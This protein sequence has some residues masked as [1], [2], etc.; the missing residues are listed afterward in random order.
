VD[1]NLIL[2]CVVIVVALFFSY[3]N[4]FHDAANAIATS[5]STRAWTPRAALLMAATMNVIGAMMGTAVAKT[6]GKGIISISDYAESPLPEMQQKGLV[7]ILAALLGACIWNLITWWFGLPSSSSHALIGGMVGAGLL[8]GTMVHWW[9]IMSHVVIPMFASPIIGFVIGYFVMKLVLWLLRNAQY[10]RTMRRFR[11]AQRFS[12]AAMALGHGI[13]DAQKT[14]GIIV[15]ALL[16]GGYGETH[17]ILDPITG[18]M[19]VPLWVKISGA[20]AISLGTMAGGGR[21]MRTIGRKIIDLDPARVLLRHSRP[22]L[23]DAGRVDGDHGCGLHE[24]LLGSS[25][26]RRGQHRHRM[27]PDATRR[28]PGVGRRVPPGRSAAGS[29]LVARARLI[30]LA[31]TLALVAPLTA[32]SDTSVMHMQVGQCILLPEEKTATTV[33][34]TNCTSEHDAEVFYM[35]SVDD[36]DF[37]GEAALNNA[38]EKVCISN[39][40][41]YV[42]SHYVTSTLDATWMLPT[43]DSWAQNDRSITCLARLLDHSKLTKSVKDSGL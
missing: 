9:G 24:A 42:G 10:H 18:E 17:N 1:L 13:Q 7:I 4:G 35:T 23:D 30:G 22:H 29:P 3:T 27:V 5:V 16:A 28:S 38:A 34:T 37:P 25:M 33:E 43:K 31:A 32:C 39:F 20:L 2:V 21:I 26:G 11:A 41:D 14:M 36:G 19:N 40:K 8:S 12:S 15:M 6:V